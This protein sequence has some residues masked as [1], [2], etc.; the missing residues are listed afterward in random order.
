MRGKGFY[1]A[2]LPAVAAVL[3][4]VLA[5]PSPAT[6]GKGTKESPKEES[7]TLE[8]PVPPPPFF[9]HCPDHVLAAI[10]MV[11]FSK[12]SAGLPGTV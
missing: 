7:S 2:G 4:L 5:A 11:L 3:L 12:P 9:H 10:S 8:F 6:H 1:H